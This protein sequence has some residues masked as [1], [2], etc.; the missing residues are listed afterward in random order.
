MTTGPSGDVALLRAEAVFLNADP[1]VK[2]AILADL[3][4]VRLSH[5][6]IQ[7]VDD[8][9]SEWV[10]DVIHVCVTDYPRDWYSISLTEKLMHC[11]PSKWLI[12]NRLLIYWVIDSIETLWNSPSIPSLLAPIPSISVHYCLCLCLPSH[13]FTSLSFRPPISS[14]IIHLFSL[15]AIT[16]YSYRYQYPVIFALNIIPCF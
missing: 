10:N 15:P 1:A 8:L 13:S 2:E 6:P 14:F 4:P 3:E 12:N 7:W 16:L 9:M 5:I 11:T